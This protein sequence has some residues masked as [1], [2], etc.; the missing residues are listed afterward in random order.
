[1]TK[2]RMVSPCEMT[3]TLL[4]SAVVVVHVVVTMGVVGV[5]VVPAVVVV[6]VVG[7]LVVPAGCRS[8][9]RLLRYLCRIIDSRKLEVLS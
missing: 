8:L 6:V 5:V 9:A 7:L 1:M 2:Q 4:Q 3:S